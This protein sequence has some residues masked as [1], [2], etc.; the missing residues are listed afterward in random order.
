MAR[1]HAV[2]TRMSWFASRVS[3][4]VADA[5]ALWRR[6]VRTQRSR[7]SWFANQFALFEAESTHQAFTCQCLLENGVGSETSIPVDP[8]IFAVA[9][10]SHRLE[11]SQFQCLSM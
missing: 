9:D 7:R 8:Q 10:G 3:A 4:T 5:C 1:V 6:D 11:V 2:D